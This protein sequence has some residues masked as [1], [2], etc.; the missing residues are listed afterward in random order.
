MEN[1]TRCS[2]DMPLDI[3]GRA[4]KIELLVYRAFRLSKL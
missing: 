4:I 3:L 2:F 1:E